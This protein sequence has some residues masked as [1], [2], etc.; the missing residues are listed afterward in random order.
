MFQVVDGVGEERGR[1]EAAES[2]MRQIL[3]ED[4][5]EVDTPRVVE[6]ACLD[7]SRI[8]MCQRSRYL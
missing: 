8:S 1:C 7:R 5:C 2:F 3:N 6:M 4:R